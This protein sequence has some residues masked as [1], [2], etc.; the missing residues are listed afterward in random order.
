MSVTMA[1]D[2]KARWSEF[3]RENPK[4]RIRDAAAALGVSEA[5]LLATRCGGGGVTRLAGDWKEVLKRLPALGNVMCLTRNEAAVHERKG[6]FSEAEFFGPMGQVVGADIDLR[7]F[8]QI[9]SVGFAVVD[10]TPDGPRRSLQFFDGTGTAIHK[11]YAKED[12]GAAAFDAIVADYRSENQE[13]VEAGLPSP[14][15]KADRPDDEIDVAGFRK[16][17]SEIQDTHEFFGLLRKHGAGRL[18]ALRLAG[19]DWARPADADAVGQ[20]LDKAAADGMAIMVFVGNPGIIQ[21]HTGLV[22]NIKRFG[23]WLNVLDDAFNLHLREDLIASAWVVRKPTRDGVV[24]S[25]EIYDANGGN[26]ALFFGKRKPGEAENMAWRELA[27]SL[28]CS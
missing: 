25:L 18:Q 28:A 27:E 11:V 2:L 1:D 14:P 9:W 3:V 13:P 15:A 26:I 19:D 17:W 16:G 22:E 6:M 20:M 10:E 5:E 8:M 24:T 7:L 12:G 23:T 21:I 4:T